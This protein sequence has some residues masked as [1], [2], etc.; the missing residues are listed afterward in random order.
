MKIKNIYIGGWFQRTML[1]LSE[2]YDFLRGEPTQVALDNAILAQNLKMVDV[3]ELSYS[4]SGEEFLEYK[5]KDE[6]HV[7]IF[8]DGLIVLK[9]EAS[10]SEELTHDIDFVKAYYEKSLSKAINY[11]FSLGA[12]VPKE[13]AHIENVYPYFVV[14][15][16][17]KDAELQELLDSTGK[18]KY[19]T[20]KNDKYE[21][22]RGDVYYFINSKTK[23]D[24]LIERYIEEEI[25]IRDFKNQLHRYLNIHRIVWEK[26]DKVKE[27]PNIKGSEIL[28][29]STKL[30]GYAKTINLID[31]RLKQMS[32]YLP[33]R[34]KIAKNDAE[35]EEFLNISGYKYETLKDT[36]NYV[37]YLWDM[38]KQHVNSAQSLFAGL[39]SD[40]TSKSIKNLAII[41]ALSAGTQI[42]NL[43]TKGSP[44]FTWFG[45]AYVIVLIVACFGL[46]KWLKFSA[47]QRSYKIS[48]ADYEK[49]I[50]F[51]EEEAREKI[52]K[53][54]RK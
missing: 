6:I 31:G 13:L 32:T 47:K 37:Q 43:L 22:R 42:I 3:N 45:I 33:T 23:E 12:P 39:K 36:L 54:K 50:E 8:E 2:I 30:D 7:K 51:E 24:S 16:N 14:C 9:K 44:V 20:F 53:K 27:N 40:V 19:F 35:L 15:N 52:N 5:T 10:T 18:Q 49:N 28:K 38:T 29:I 48:D 1:Q 34:E 4:V 26:I 17:A 46:N 41:T 25:F 11:L 21:V